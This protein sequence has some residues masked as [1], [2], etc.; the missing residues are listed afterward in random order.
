M[1]DAKDEAIAELK[2]QH[3]NA[4]DAAFAAGQQSVQPEEDFSAKTWY[5]G[6]TREPALNVALRAEFEKQ[7][8]EGI[9]RRTTA[10]SEAIAEIYRAHGRS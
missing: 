8:R 7:G 5:P 1:T 6:R 4:V 3:Q 2:R 9:A 10:N